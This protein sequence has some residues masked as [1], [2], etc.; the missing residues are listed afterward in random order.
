[1]VAKHPLIILIMKQVNSLGFP[2]LLS[3]IHADN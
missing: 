1:M 2:G 3:F